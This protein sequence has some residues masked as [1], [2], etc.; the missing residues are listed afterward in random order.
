MKNECW[1]IIEK[2]E[3]HYRVYAVGYA[4]FDG[5]PHYTGVAYT[6]KKDAVKALKYYG[7]GYVEAN[8]HIKRIKKY[9]GTSYS[10]ENKKVYE[11]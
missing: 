3:W 7:K 10:S 1:D 2:S 6:L 8:R 11:L 5:K 9:D 4:W